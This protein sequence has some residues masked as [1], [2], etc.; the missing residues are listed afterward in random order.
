MGAGVIAFHLQYMGDLMEP[1]ECQ[2]LG[3]NLGAISCFCGARTFRWRAG[4]AT[5]KKWEAFWRQGAV[6]VGAGIA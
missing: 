6:Q 4:S 2:N 1:L 5:Y 3:G